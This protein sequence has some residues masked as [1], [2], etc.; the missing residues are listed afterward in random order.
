M[1][2]RVCQWFFKK[3]INQVSENDWI[4]WVNQAFQNAVADVG[5]LKQSFKND[6]KM[7]MSLPDGESRIINLMEQVSTIVEKHDH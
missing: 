6:L 5:R 1:K 4:A 3:Q 7:D 2:R